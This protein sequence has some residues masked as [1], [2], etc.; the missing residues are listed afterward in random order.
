M[1]QFSS[2]DNKGGI[3]SAKW[4]TSSYGFGGHVVRTSIG[5]AEAAEY[6]H[7]A[8]DLPWGVLVNDGTQ[9]NL[10][11]V[12][13]ENV[14]NMRNSLNGTVNIGDPIIL[15]YTNSGGT[16]GF[17]RSAY[18]SQ[19]IASIAAGGDIGTHVIPRGPLSN[20]AIPGSIRETGTNS[21]LILGASG[22]VLFGVNAGAFGGGNFYYQID[23]PVLGIAKERATTPRQLFKVE[24]VKERFVKNNTVN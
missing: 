9:N 23:Q 5:T 13:T 8:A 1:P 24:I 10:V 11:T 19:A 17:V 16:A 20:K 6:C 14:I 12:A 18:T 2:G 3:R 15:D 21:Y 22:T 7:A 4:N